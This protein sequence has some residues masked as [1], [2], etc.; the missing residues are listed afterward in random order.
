[1][2]YSLFALK[3]VGE[4]TMGEFVKGVHEEYKAAF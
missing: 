3:I 4:F 1:M 2:Y